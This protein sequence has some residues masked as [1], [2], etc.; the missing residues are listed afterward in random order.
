MA[1][2]IEAQSAKARFN[3]FGGV[4][5][6]NVLT[7]LGLIYFLRTGWVVGQVGMVGALVIV[8]LAN[9]ISLLTGLSLSSVA[10]SMTVRTGG[11]Y[12]ILART[13]G[14][15]IGGAIGIPLFLS[16]AVSVS[17][18]V[19]GFTEALAWIAP[20]IYPWRQW[21]STGI[22]LL[23]GILA[24]VGADFA[25]KI[26]YVVLAVLMLA[27]LSFYLGGFGA[28]IEPVLGPVPDDLYKQYDNPFYRE[29]ATPQGFWVVFAV[30][31]PAVTGIVVGAS[32]SGDL[33]DPGKS[34]PRGTMYSII[35][36]AIIYLTSTVWIGLTATR[37]DL[38]TNNLVMQQ[39]ALFP[40][41]K[42]VLIGV[43]AAT[44][45]S[46]LGSVLAAPRT[47][48]AL[49]MDRVFPRALGSQ[50]GHKT[51]PR[52]GVIV[53]VIIALVFVW[54]GSLNFV[55]TVVSMFVLA[56]YG[57]MNLAAGFEQL[58]GNPSYRPTF[59]LHWFWSLLGAAGSF[60]VMFLINVPATL[61]VLGVMAAAFFGL[62]RRA[63]KTEFGDLRSGIWASIARHSLLKLEFEPKRTKNWRPHVIVFTGQP[64][65]REHLVEV[66][67]WLQR[68]N[69]LVTF[70]E[71][72]V[73]NVEKL[74]LSGVRHERRDRI[75]E[76]IRERRLDAFAEC[77]IASDFYEGAITV[78]QSHGMAGLEPNTVLMGL[79]ETSEGLTRQL[80][81]MPMLSSLRKSVLLL[82]HDADKG[83]GQRARIDVWWGGKS[84][85]GELMLLLAHI[86]RSHPEWTG[87]K[88]RLL[89][90]CDGE[91]Q[92]DETRGNLAKLLE[93]VRVRATAKAVVRHEGETAA[94]TI[95]RTSGDAGMTIIG[96][97]M[98]GQNDAD[99]LAA[100]VH[101]LIDPLGSVLL[102]RSAETEDVLS[103][104]TVMIPAL[105]ERSE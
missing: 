74:A 78:A 20:E 37:E 18:Y 87:S 102:V 54:A 64:R 97:Q 12:Y 86:I 5:V 93:E 57:V 83:Y 89:Q 36:T 23:F 70:A 25:I 94:D 79:S 100:R 8:A 52:A 45:S 68:G 31:F 96:M 72:V 60:G 48:Q 65:N 42:L 32:M 46:A 56:T 1:E 85:N 38:L 80:Q 4:F 73:G 34:I 44:L 81:L 69:G 66:G 95:A 10:T 63:L 29:L 13:L 76:F 33:K 6:P 59:R 103:G 47:M 24:W 2:A 105:P 91:A 15:E 77:L 39:V 16:L 49:A 3:T 101:Q 28:N 35:F 88:V 50:L 21:I 98:P 62:E 41:L 7:I 75:A 61:V 26:Q 40:G 9:L 17:F 71:I 55:A 84:R 92:A 104:D 51:E 99:E 67:E 11:V 27:I 22:V 43:W 58:V 19:I 30:Y 90:I 82:K 53:S 14:L